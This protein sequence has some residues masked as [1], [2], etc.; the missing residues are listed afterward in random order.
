[1]FGND[2]VSGLGYRG[3]TDDDI[4][5]TTEGFR[6]LVRVYLGPYRIRRNT[7]PAPYIYPTHSP[8]ML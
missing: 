7:P 5:T 8:T 1:M 6:D 2:E 4:R 3:G